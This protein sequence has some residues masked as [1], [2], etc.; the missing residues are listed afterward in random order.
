MIKPNTPIDEARRLFALRR[1]QIL[2]TEAEPGFDHITHLARQIINAPIALISLVD[3]NRQWFKSKSGLNLQET[4][5]DISF[6]GHTILDDQTL[7]VADA[8][9]DKRFFDNPLV[10]AE[11]HIRAYGGVPLHAPT[12]E[13]IGAI[14][15]MDTRERYFSDSELKSLSMLA[16][17]VEDMFR[18]T[19]DLLHSAYYDSVTGLPNQLLLH[20]KL[21]AAIAHAD[22]QS[23]SIAVLA[24]NIDQFKTINHSLGHCIGDA[25]LKNIA[26]RIVECVGTKGVVGRNGADEFC[27]IQSPALEQEAVALLANS[28]LERLAQPFNIDEHEITA[29]TSIGV[30]VFPKNNRSAV[31]LLACADMALA[32]AKTSGCNIA[33]YYTE[34]ICTES[35]R[36]FQLYTDL[37]QALIRQEFELYYQPELDIAT[38]NIVGAEALLRWNHPQLG[39]LRPAD[40]IE[41]A[42][43]SGL[44]IPIGEW[45]LQEACREA[46]KWRNHDLSHCRVTVKLS[47]LQLKRD[48][49]ECA[50]LAALKNTALP[51]QLL[52]LELAGSMLIDDTEHMLARISHLKALDIELAVGD[53]GI[54]HSS[55]AHLRRLPFNKLKIDQSFIRRLTLSIKDQAIVKAI[56]QLA[57]SLRLKTLA[58]G[59]ETIEQL[60]QLRALGC[61]SAQGFLFSKPLQAATLQQLL[62]KPINKTSGMESID[63][64][65]FT[66]DHQ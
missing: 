57:D 11:P 19:D 64:R 66:A 39:L 55:L 54:S 27:V 21:N 44:I 61:G 26:R 41:V 42:E 5:R 35:H 6:C 25:L 56:I 53:F 31:G 59:V 36:R 15:V 62:R 50:V 3:E 13:R 7:T 4:P 1:L 14:C 38:G 65:T 33:S 49:I 63:Y 34:E 12:G 30:S 37:R 60:E 29:T 43:E 47:A 48:S 32:Q 8:K 16:S 45:V 40:F 51:P 52:E 24:I 23:H 2:D 22:E 10:V 58:E 28:I 20:E 46:Q 9:K 17:I 18:R